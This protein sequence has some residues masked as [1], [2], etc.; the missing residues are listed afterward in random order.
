MDSHKVF[1]FTVQ[2]QYNTYMK[3]KQTPC[4]IYSRK[5]QNILHKFSNDI[6]KKLSAVFIGNVK[7]SQLAKTKMAKSVLDAGW[8]MLKTMLEYKCDHAGVVFQEIDERYTTQAC[9]CCGCISTNSPK[10]R[11]GLRIREWSCTGCGA[12]HDRDINASRIFLPLGL[13][14]SREESPTIALVLSGGRKSIY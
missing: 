3:P 11:A 8:H 10:G 2:K 5:N 9:S 6:V 1:F 13:E 4:K 12:K 14:V 7:S